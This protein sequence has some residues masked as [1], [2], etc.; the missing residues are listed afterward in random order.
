MYRELFG[1]VTASND[2][3]P[4]AS[5]EGPNT[6]NKLMRTPKPAHTHPEQVAF[7]CVE[8]LIQISEDPAHVSVSLLALLELLR[9]KYLVNSAAPKQEPSLRLR[10]HSFD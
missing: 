9:H 10:A 5:V 3:C 6:C 1:F 2:A 4:H 8:G 7:D